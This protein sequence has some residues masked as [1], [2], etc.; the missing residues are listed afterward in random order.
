LISTLTFDILL[1]KK[2]KKGENMR[3]TAP[4]IILLSILL[5]A[6]VAYGSSKHEKTSVIKISPSDV[7]EKCLKLKPDQTLNYSF[8][9]SQPLAFNL[10]Y[11]LLDKTVFHVKEETSK[12]K[13][14]F[15]P[16]KKQS[17]YC[18]EWRNIDSEA[19]KIEYKYKISGK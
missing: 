2:L 4:V 18:M 11:H 14:V 19:V 7:Y 1:L 10:H 8:E 9:S 5:I 17:V 16:V 13:E 3:N 12:R 15:H 6:T